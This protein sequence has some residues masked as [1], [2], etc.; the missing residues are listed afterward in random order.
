MDLIERIEKFLNEGKVNHVVPGLIKSY[1]SKDDTISKVIEF[2]DED[3][4]L[5]GQFW[6]GKL[7]KKD[8][9]VLAFYSFDLGTQ[10]KTK[11]FSNKEDGMKV[12]DSIKQNM[13]Y[14]DILKLFK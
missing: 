2:I 10:A 4:K 7:S 11:T 14:D 5:G 6:F 3:E 13:K 1:F 12:Y 9:Y 8:V